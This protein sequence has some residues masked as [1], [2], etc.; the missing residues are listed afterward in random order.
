MGILYSKEQWSSTWRFELHTKFFC[1]C[2]NKQITKNSLIYL[3]NVYFSHLVCLTTGWPYIIFHGAQLVSGLWGEFR[4]IAH[5]FIF[6]KG[7]HYPGHITFMVDPG[8]R[9]YKPNHTRTKTTQSS[10]N[11]LSQS[12]IHN[13]CR[14]N[15]YYT[16]KGYGEMGEWRKYYQL[17]Q[18][19]EHK[20]ML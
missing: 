3:A 15:V 18:I 10:W 11:R 16:P 19:H 17:I 2:C 13:L 7:K 9:E 8:V 6:S 14:R 4:Y 1:Y 20:K 5:V 12:Y